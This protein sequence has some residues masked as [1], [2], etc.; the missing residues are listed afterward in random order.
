MKLVQTKNA[1]SA[2]GP[3]SQAIVVGDLIFCSGQIGIDPKTG[4]L[5]KGIEEQAKQVLENIMAVLEAAGSNHNQVVKTTIFLTNIADFQKIN[6]IY[7][8]YFGGHKP[9]R[10]T[11]E[12]KNLPKGALIEVE[13]TAKKNVRK[14]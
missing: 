7:A 5:K 4:E 13:A 8:A 2:I 3:Y 11:V 14:A 10:S 12:V 9:A 6:E 1:P